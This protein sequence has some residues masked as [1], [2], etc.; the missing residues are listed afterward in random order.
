M[1]KR[2]VGRFIALILAGPTLMFAAAGRLDWW[3]GWLVT[4]FTV[5]MQLG[6]R[7]LLMRLNPD[8]AAERAASS[9]TEGKGVAP[10]DKALVP[11]VALL[12]PLISLLVAG[13]D[14]RWGWSPQV[15][16]LLWALCLII[17]AAG[18]LFST[19]AMLTNRFFAAYVRI[20]QERSHSVVREGPYS[21]VRHPGYAGALFGGLACVLVLGSWWALVPAG[22]TS[23]AIIV[24]AALEDR[25][26]R[27]ELPGY[28][29]YAQKVRF[30]LLPRV[31]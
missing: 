6:S 28:E 8:L 20:Q 17:F 22:L 31:W 16:Q 26:L 2:A 18:Y 21:V 11:I 5:A 27:T 14:H 24:R 19:W 30:R 13:L 25:F 10:W 12:G 9:D 3:E 1:S 23:V 7:L 15:P 4:A 29:T